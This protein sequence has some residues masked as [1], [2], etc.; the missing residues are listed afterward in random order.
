MSDLTL[1]GDASWQC[2]WVF[3]AMVAL[4]ELGVLYKLEPL[5]SPIDPDLKAELAAHGLIDNTPCLIHGD[6]WLTESSAISEYLAETFVPPKHR[7][8]MPASTADRARAR[9]IMAWLRTSLRGLRE[10]RP[11]SGVFMRSVTAPLSDK[12][13]AD[14]E[15]LIRVAER[16]IPSGR[17]TLCEEWSMA[18]LD[19]ALALTRLIAS[20]D[21]VP[22]RLVDYAMATWGRVS[23]RKYLA[24]IPTIH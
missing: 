20:N 24:H 19:L 13:R 8:I 3:H 4:E 17:T 11:T 15:Q 7:R 9:Q 22:E 16:A 23:V 18:D 12:G 14:A 10:D 6:F 5:R 1:Y 2:P 21:S